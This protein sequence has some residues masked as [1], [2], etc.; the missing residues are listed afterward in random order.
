[1][2]SENDADLD[3]YKDLTPAG[4]AKATG[5]LDLI[6]GER[7]ELLEERRAAI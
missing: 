6:K 2:A 3:E 7:K 5:D 1:M 4:I